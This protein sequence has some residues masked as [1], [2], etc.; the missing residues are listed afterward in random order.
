MKALHV[1]S[2]SLLLLFWLLVLHLLFLWVPFST[3]CLVVLAILMTISLFSFSYGVIIFTTS[4]LFFSSSTFLMSS[5]TWRD[6][7]LACHWHWS[8][9]NQPSSVLASTHNCIYD[10]QPTFNSTRNFKA[11]RQIKLTWFSLSLLPPSLQQTC[12][13]YALAYT[14]TFLAQSL[15]RAEQIKNE[16]IL[17]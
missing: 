16:I 15:C 1:L 8:S 17:A 11:S 12:L 6:S 13:E 14:S 7:S 9:K 5:I 10:T 4:S 2:F 3:S